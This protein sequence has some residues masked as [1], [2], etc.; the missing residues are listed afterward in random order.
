VQTQLSGRTG[1]HHINA[2]THVT[3]AI[4]DLQTA[5]KIN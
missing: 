4:A 1:Q 3:N 5:L 2:N